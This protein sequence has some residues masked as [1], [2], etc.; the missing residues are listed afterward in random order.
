MRIKQ[1]F[2]VLTCCL[3]LIK[4]AFA[5]EVA[6]TTLSANEQSVV[7]TAEE[8]SRALG[9]AFGDALKQNLKR[10]PGNETIQMNVL[11]EGLCSYVR[12]VDTTLTAKAANDI[13]MQYFKSMEQ[14]INEKIKEQSRAY[15]EQNAKNKDVHVT[16]SGLQY[17]I[18]SLGKGPKSTVEDTVVV[19]YKG[20]LTD[21]T[22]FDSSYD[23]GE[24]TKFSPLQ[25]IPGWTEGLCL[26]P[27]GSK[28]RLVIPEQLAYGA[29]GA[30]QKIPPYSTLIFEIELLQVIKGAPIP[31]AES[32]STN[33]SAKNQKEKNSENRK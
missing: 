5:Q 25:V 32:I 11:L 30:G 12:G 22:V 16:E 7:P 3:T 31:V 24:P 33:A 17:E 14:S 6:D 20:M 23:R 9:V 19:H 8:A 29:R 10:F 2:I 26:L 27:Q 28:A 13:V 18:L 4:S 15:L 1:F 21:G